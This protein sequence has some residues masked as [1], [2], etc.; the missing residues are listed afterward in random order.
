MTKLR[1]SSIEIIINAR[2]IPL[3]QESVSNGKSIIK[4]LL[5]PHPHPRSSTLTLQLVTSV[6]LDRGPA[7]AKQTT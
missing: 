4:V 2:V 7:A 5:S 1:I 3:G 6:F